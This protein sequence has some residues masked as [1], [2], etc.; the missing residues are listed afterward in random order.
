MS[1]RLSIAVAAREEEDTS[2]RD[3]VL[4]GLFA[5]PKVLPP[6]HFYDARGSELF[7]AICDTPEYYPTRAED[8]LLEKHAGDILEAAAPRYLIELGSGTARKT[9]RLFDAAAKLALDLTYVPVDVSETTLRQSADALLSEYPWLKVRG[10]VGSFYDGLER[11]PTEPPRLFAFLGGTI[12]NFEPAAA[13][14]FLRSLHERM[15]P[16]DRFLLG[17]DLV[18]DPSLLEAAYNDAQGITAAFNKNVLTVMNRELD[19]NFDL[20]AFEHLAFFDRHLAQ[21]EMH[22]VSRRLQK[23]HLAKLGVTAHFQTGERMRT[24]VSRKFTP[25][26]LRALLASAGMELERFFVPEDGAFGLSLARAV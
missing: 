7:D 13:T 12:G 9:R 26:S 22:L 24:E 19:A 21:I 8:A 3:D 15:D 4:V 10:V 6:R 25:E 2:L 16:E 23:V 18:K 17:T 20:S 5:S 1:P 11:L 14:R